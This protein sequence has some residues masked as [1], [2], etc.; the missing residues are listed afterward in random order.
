MKILIFEP[1]VGGHFTNYIEYL[2]PTL[3]LLPGIKQVV[4][5]ITCEHLESVAFKQQLAHYESDIIIFDASIEQDA[6]NKSFFYLTSNLKSSVKRNNPDYVVVTTSGPLTAPMSFRHL[7]GFKIF[8][9]F[10]DATAIFH[11]GYGTSASCWKHNLRNYMH[12]LSWKHSPWNHLLIVN[13]IVYQ[14]A[15]QKVKDGKL[16]SRIRLLPD[17]IPEQKVVD[18]KTARRLL[19]L[20]TDGRLIGF[21]GGIQSR[22][23]LPELLYAFREATSEP[24][25]RILLAGKICPSHR[26][27]IDVNF[28]D[29]VSSGRLL[30]LDR[31]L[32]ENECN[33]GFCALDASTILYYERPVLSSLLLRSISAR[34]PVIAY[35]FGYSGFMLR[36][37]KLGWLSPLN[38]QQALTQTVKKVLYEIEDFEFDL[39]LPRLLDFHSP[40]NYAYTV[41][42]ELLK[43]KFPSYLPL[44]RDWDWVT[45]TS[46]LES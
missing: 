2:L 44:I 29:L 3:L 42:Y 41:L 34:C 4:V 38:D 19:G 14:W 45:D 5:S 23:A 10:V 40:S 28:S 46:Y 12:R 20:P 24:T 17:P 32:D 37:F 6:M 9:R 22:V 31:Y 7:F 8:P 39:R 27:L 18:R 1:G 25:D 35:E 33:L 11:A 21:I 16:R 26:K 30:I 15:I 43:T 13:P 36:E